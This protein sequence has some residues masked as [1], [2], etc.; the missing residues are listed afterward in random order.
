VFKAQK[1]T[2]HGTLYISN[3]RRGTERGGS[4]KVWPRDEAGGYVMLSELKK[5]KKGEQTRV[6]QMRT[7]AKENTATNLFG[8]KKGTEEEYRS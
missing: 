2:K 1:K 5:K 3:S 6:H 8:N 7:L 4:G